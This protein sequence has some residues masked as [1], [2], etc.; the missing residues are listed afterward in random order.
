MK[1]ATLPKSRSLKDDGVYAVAV[2][3]AF[4][5]IFRLED[6]DATELILVRHAEPDHRAA[7]T[8]GAAWDPPL[9]ERGRQQAMR[10]AMRLRRAEVERIYTSTARVALETAALL[11][12]AK[13]LPMIRTPQLQGVRF[14]SGSLNG[15]SGDPSKMT[16]DVTLRFIN[17]P[18]WDSLRGFESSRDFRHR[19]VQTVESIISRHTGER[20]VLV[21]H[22]S[23]INAYLS[24]VLDIGRDMFFLPEYTSLS[25]LRVLRD[26]YGVQSIN[27]QAHLL[28]TFN[29]R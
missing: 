26:A 23:V 2:E 12:A 13:D 8:N 3:T 10:L 19:A 5:K 21:T 18:R 25:T 17:Q 9:S 4:D 7:R 22:E 29:P 16:A 24:M 15:A 20:I 14:H 11:A 28:P 27:D 6:A 1:T